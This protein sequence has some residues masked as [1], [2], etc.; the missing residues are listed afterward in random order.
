MWSLQLP[1]L[2]AALAVRLVSA[3]TATTVLAEL[4]AL[5]LIVPVAS[6]A[7]CN[8]FLTAF[9]VSPLERCGRTVADEVL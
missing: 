8:P 2:V 5:T 4:N 3:Q 7:S 1:L 6:V 9:G